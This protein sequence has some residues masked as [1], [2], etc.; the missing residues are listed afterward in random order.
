MG[1]IAD[2]LAEISVVSLLVLTAIVT[3]GVTMRYVFNNALTWA[4]EVASYSLLAMVFF[5]VAHTLHADAHIKIDFFLDRLP[6]RMRDTIMLVAYAIGLVFAAVL[7]LA[8]WA[9]IE[10]FWLRHTVSF[11][12]LRTPLFLPALPLLIGSVTFFLMMLATALQHL[13]GMVRRAGSRAA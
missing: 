4:D 12:D 10:N 11:T 3:I 6:A 13:A 7:I 8:C 9:R 5:G 2:W 1:R